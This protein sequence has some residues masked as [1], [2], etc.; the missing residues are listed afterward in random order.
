[1][2]DRPAHRWEPGPGV[3]ELPDGR[4]VRGRALRRAVPPGPHPDHGYY[5]TGRRPP[6]TPWP[7]TWVRWPDF[8]VPLRWRTAYAVLSRAHAESASRRVEVACGGGLGRTGTALACLVTLSGLPADDAVGYV[9][10]RY[11]ARAVETPWQRAFVAWFD[12]R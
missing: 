10:E 6:P 11:A 4:R 3:L 9:R 5:L 1:M 8:L 2:A 7:Q 12:R